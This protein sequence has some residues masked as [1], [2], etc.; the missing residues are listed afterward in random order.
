MKRHCTYIAL[1][2][3][4]ITAIIPSDAQKIQATLSHYSTDNGMPSNSVSDIKQDAY[5]YL[6]ISTWNGLARFD[7]YNFC[8]YETGSSSHIPM[9][10][11]RIIDMTIDKRQNIWLRMYDGRIFVLDRRSDRIVNPFAGTSAGEAVKTERPLLATA[12]GAVTA[13][14]N[15]KRMAWLHLTP[16][17][18][19][20]RLLPV[21]E[22]QTC[23]TE[24]E[25]GNVWTGT[26]DGHISR[27][28]EGKPGPE[29]IRT[30]SPV[31]C[32][33]TR[34]NTAYA[35]LADGRIVRFDTTH[36]QEDYQEVTREQTGVTTIFVDSQNR[37]W[38]STHIS[39]IIR[40]DLTSRNR[41][42]FTQQVL[43]PQE[44]S[45]GARICEVN[46]RIWMIL[47]HGG[48][49][50]YNQEKD[51]IE[52]FYN[53][54]SMPWNLSNATSCFQ[55][56]REG[57]VWEST[58]R[59]GLEKLVIMKRTINRTQ[60]FESNSRAYA[61]D[62]RALYYDRKQKRLLIGSKSGS[63][64][65]YQ[66][67]KVS[68]ID[69]DGHGQN[70][71]R[72]YHINSDSQNRYWICTKGHGLYMM[73]AA[74]GSYLKGKQTHF[75][76]Q[77][78]NKWSLSSD[79]VYCTVE[80]REGNIWIATYDGGVNIFPRRQRGKSL[81]IF[82]KNN[83]LKHYPDLSF[84]KVRTLTVDGEGRVWAGT[85]DGLLVM[86]LHNGIVRTET[87]ADPKGYADGLRSYDIVCLAT[88]SRGTVWIGTNGGGLSHC[89]GRGT[90][91]KWHFETFDTHDGLPS[92]E[93]RSITFDQRGYVWF[94]TDHSLCSFDPH[95]RVFS[96]FGMEDGIDDTSCSEAAALTLPDGRILFG[97]INGYYTLDR[98]KL[99]K[100]KTT[101][102]KLRFTDFY[103]NDQL[104]TP[105]TSDTYSY[106]VPDST[107]V[108]LPTHGSMFAFRF[109]SLNYELQQRVHY[110]YKLE[111]FD[112]DWHNA[113]KSRT[114]SYSGVP[115]GNYKLVIRAFLL[116][117][118]DQYA[119]CT[120][121]VRVPPYF[122]L[123]TQ[124]IWI[125]ILL[126]LLTLLT[127]LYLRQQQLARRE[128]MRVLKVGPQEI[129]FT[130][131][132]DY[133]FV[134]QQLDWLEQHYMDS[135][136]KTD[137][138]V[139][140]TGMS[141]TSYYLELKQ[142]TGLSPKEL[143][144]DFRLKKAQM[145]LEKTDSTVAEIAYKTGFN[146]PVYFTRLFR[147]KIGLPPTKYREE[148]RNP[149]T[150]ENKEPGA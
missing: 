33:C 71:G 54:P 91:G 70:I 39:G 131:K 90:D 52:Y 29:N 123:S 45:N 31:N 96:T 146:D 23:M 22:V 13:I 83:V 145:Y 19:K 130:H 147:Q 38:L 68:T 138:L 28:K 24:D 113:G 74:N 73:E 92:E 49:G 14:V 81:K 8:N 82:N 140:P 43:S 105:R 12:D 125:Y 48:F 47:N 126:I 149:P 77:P 58:N 66:K 75:S 104:V 98:H 128:K 102:L 79:N 134:K 144:L 129:A 56:M 63:I 111:G 148:K 36:P 35:G 62:I 86:S 136:L 27:W 11:N 21:A 103:L 46:G 55:I 88:D 121:N 57:V 30:G 26:A 3:G 124:A 133:N 61:N 139:G 16:Q 18:L 112:T 67:G 53:D 143:I 72:I 99:K 9:L 97:T 76:A 37:L 85:T 80:D 69:T 150:E 94:G 137:D 65:I 122:L 5:G 119:V 51:C 120:M 7:G 78:G 135:T 141:R 44:D 32:I 109:A 2:V 110:Q 4:L 117:A 41:K 6:W 95:K 89:L 87:V 101:D 42:H 59:R 20:N 1:T 118:P 108:E 132:D 34:G 142:L 93:V 60:P 40:L 127:L 25:R 115:T 116:E 106:Y 64:K 114:V 50:Y 15:G 84:Q 107:S 10:H 100:V 17:G